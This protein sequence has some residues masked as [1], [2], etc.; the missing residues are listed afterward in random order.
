MR[1]RVAHRKLGRTTEHR[2]SLLRNMAASLITHERI[3]TTVAKAKEL[4]PFVEKLV[5]LGKRDSLHAR[6]R[7][8]SILSSKTVVRRLFSD[9]SPRFSERPGGY[10]RILKL[11]PRQGDGAPMAFIEFVDYQFKGGEAPAPA[12]KEK[13]KAKAKSKKK[14]EPAEPVEK[15]VEEA[16]DV[17]EPK[18]EKPAKKKAAKKKTTAKKATKKKTTKKKSS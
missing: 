16:A 15:E 4:R 12:A 18:A 9:V 14:D 5:T 7:A 8:L 10:T 13:P 11:G 6:R 1:H 3:R 2:L 17:E